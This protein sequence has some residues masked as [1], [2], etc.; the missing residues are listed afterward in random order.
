MPA[1]P[2][3]SAGARSER[4]ALRSYLRR[5]IKSSPSIQDTLVWQ[6][7]LEW[8]LTRQRRYDKKGGGLGKK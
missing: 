8:V 2:K 1:D 3:T 4:Q 5:R 7:A 6:Q